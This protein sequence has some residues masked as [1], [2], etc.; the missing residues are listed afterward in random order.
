MAQ[1]GMQGKHAALRK[2]GENDARIGNSAFVLA[3]D[4]RRDLLR[5]LSQVVCLFPARREI[6]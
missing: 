5:R 4:Q 1:A 6:G 2:A 3:R